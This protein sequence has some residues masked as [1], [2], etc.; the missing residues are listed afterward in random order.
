MNRKK[1]KIIKSFRDKSPNYYD[2]VCDKYNSMSLEVLEDHIRKYYEAD[3]SSSFDP[4]IDKMIKAGIK[5]L[6]DG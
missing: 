1:E 5:E 4:K 3:G 2:Y 6:A